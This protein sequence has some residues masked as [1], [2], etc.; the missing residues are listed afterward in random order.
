MAK[1]TGHRTKDTGHRTK[2]H[3]TQDEGH[4][5]QDERTQDTG[6]RT[7]DEGHRTQD[8]GHR[9]QDEGHTTKDE[10][11]RKN[12]PIPAAAVAFVRDTEQG[13]EVYLSRRPSHFRYYP[14]AF[15]FPGGRVDDEDSNI[16]ETARREVMEEI[17]VDID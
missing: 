10:G 2:G 6:R 16:R 8:E 12:N 4:R 14:N 17:G 9:T 5:T 15:V 7:Q 13:I 11:H 3:R 1:D